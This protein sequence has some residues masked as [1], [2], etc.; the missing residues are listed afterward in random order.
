MSVFFKSLKKNHVRPAKFY[1]FYFAAAL[2]IS[3]SLMAAQILKGNI[4]EAIYAFDTQAII[5]FLWLITVVIAVRVLCG[6]YERD[7]FGMAM[8][9]VASHGVSLKTWRTNFAYVDQSCKLFDMT[10]KENIELGRKG[11]VQ[12]HDVTSAAKRA[13]AHDFIMQL[14]EQY[15]T[16]CGEK[17][18]FLSGG[19]RQRIAI[20]RA[21]I[22]GA[23]ILVFDEATSALDPESEK[24]IMDTIESLR[25]DHTILITTHNLNNV[26]HADKIVV[27][28][29]GKIIGIGD[30]KTLIETNEA[31]QYLFSHQQE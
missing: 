18:A 27:M 8:D 19:Q 31:Y 26:V 14:D 15:D 29:H 28:D 21:L 22:K 23:P 1:I 9:G 6:F 20:A 24:N 10:I 4:S 5:R 13:F 17:G 25:N 11:D 30:H 3:M 16:R 7:Y 12:D 2:I